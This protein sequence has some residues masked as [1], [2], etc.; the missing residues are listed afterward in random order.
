MT[1]HTVREFIVLDAQAGVRMT[2][3]GFLCAA[4]R[5]ARTGIQIYSGAEVGRPEMDKVRVFRSEDQVFSKDSTHSYTHRPV[6]NDHPPVLVDASNWKKYSVGHTG[7]EVMR[8]GDCIRVPMTLMDAAAVKDWKDGKRQLSLGYTMDLE[9]KAG[10]T[11]NG[12]EY[13]AVQTNIRANHLAVVAAARGGPLL[14]IGDHNNGDP[15]MDVKTLT[16][17]GVSVQVV[18]DAS[19]QVITRHL[20]RIGQEMDKMKK[21]FEEEDEKKKKAKDA[22]DTLIADQ[23]KVIEVKD[24]EIVT[25]KA[26]VADSAM[27]PAKLDALVKDRADVILAAEKVLGD[28]LD[29]SKSNDEIRKQVVDAKLGDKAKGW[30]AD[31]I[32]AGF[33]SI[34]ANDTGSSGYTAPS[35][36]N[37]PLRDAL[38]NPLTVSD[39]DKKLNESYATYDKSLKDAWKTSTPA[40][41]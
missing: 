24:A 19:S 15:V 31:A 2:P 30:S 17:D 20:D 12:E 4:P 35:L 8:D 27:T 5:V 10:K 26:A 32:M 23:K 36:S 7:D 18:G 41:A 34:C 37:Q 13:D 25:L 1:T 39:S 16:I 40:A 11:E 22:A 6:T 29:K 33:V 3:A 38:G 14:T 21:K 9:W 28:R